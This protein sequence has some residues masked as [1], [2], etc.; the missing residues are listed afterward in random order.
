MSTLSQAEKLRD[1]KAFLVLTIR[2]D[3]YELFGLYV[4]K[5]HMK[6]HTG[7]HLPKY[8]I[9]RREG[10]LISTLYYDHCSP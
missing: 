1:G 5:E 2:M 9:A 3:T 10:F 6:E 7:Y 8:I 4:L